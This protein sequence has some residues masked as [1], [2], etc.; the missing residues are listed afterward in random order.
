M[1]Q[2]QMRMTLAEI[3]TVISDRD[4]EDEVIEAAAEKLNEVLV[5][6]KGASIP[7]QA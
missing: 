1:N 4:H 3:M 6:L 5:I 7:E 2:H